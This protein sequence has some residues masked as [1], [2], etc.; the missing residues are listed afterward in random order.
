MDT[1]IAISSSYK[2]LY[3]L[4]KEIFQAIT[5]EYPLNI[6]NYYDKKQLSPKVKMTLAY[7]LLK[8]YNSPKKNIAYKLTA[9][10]IR[11]T[12]R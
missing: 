12:N 11:K 1:I 8:S 10:S 3:L 9:E 6:I 5:L 2:K 4:P 7:F